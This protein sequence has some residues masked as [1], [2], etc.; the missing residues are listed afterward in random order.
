M[1]TMPVSYHDLVDDAPDAYESLSQLRRSSPDAG[2][3]RRNL[4]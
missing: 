4:V 2:D 3:D 1:A